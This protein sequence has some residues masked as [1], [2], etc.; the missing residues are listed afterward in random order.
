MGEMMTSMQQQRGQETEREA[1]D[2]RD[3]PLEFR[4]LVC[5]L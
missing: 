5:L 3:C 1:V 4:K 2:E